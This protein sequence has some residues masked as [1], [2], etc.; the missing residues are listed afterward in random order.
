MAV[1]QGWSTVLRKKNLFVIAALFATFFVLLLPVRPDWEADAT[2]RL[3]ATGQKNPASKSAEIWVDAE[4]TRQ[5]LANIIHQDSAWETREGFL[6][7]FRNQPGAIEA[8]VHVEPGTKMTLT[9]HDYSG[10][11]E[12][13][14]RKSVV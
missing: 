5:M 14:D 13:T 2:V 6:L 10:I 1:S 7:S 8:K 11:L 9:R 12:L 4:T 3:V